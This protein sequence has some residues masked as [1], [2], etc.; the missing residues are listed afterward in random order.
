MIGALLAAGLMAQPAVPVSDFFPR[1]E[2]VRL[3]K[4]HR[5]EGEKDWPF[6]A[7]DGELACVMSM[8]RPVVMFIPATSHGGHRPYVLDFNVFN[9]VMFNIGM[10]DVLR[11]VDKPEDI[12]P[13]IARFVIQGQMLCKYNDGQVVP[14]SEL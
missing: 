13:R 7:D 2:D 10:T 3:Q 9:M 14:G 5:V 8:G 1:T 11:H 6:V 4:I 12:I